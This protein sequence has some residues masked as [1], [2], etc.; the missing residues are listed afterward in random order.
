MNGGWWARVGLIV[1]LLLLAIYTLLPTLL[2]GSAEEELERQAQQV[3]GSAEV[4]APEV[5][6]G[7][8]SFLP[9]TELVL[10]LDLRGGIDLTLDVETDDAVLSSVARDV[11]SVLGAA[12]DD[13]LKLASVDRVR[14]QPALDVA[15]DGAS[16]D[17][18][19]SLFARRFPDYEYT[20]TQEVAGRQAHRFELTEQAQ[21]DIAQRSVEQAVE[22]LRT[23]VDATGVKEPVIVL[24]GGNRINVQLPGVED[25]EQAVAAIGTTAV[26]EF[27]LVDE[28][29]PS[30]EL[31]RNIK[32]ARETAPRN[33]YEDDEALSDWMVDNGLLPADR[34]LLWQYKEEEGA[35]VRSYPYVLKD[36]VVLTGDD[37]NDAQ[38]SM[39]Q[40]NR[41]YVALEF[42]PTGARVFA[43]V[44]GENVG[45]RFAIVLDRRV[46]SA[47]NIR[48]K[49][50][51]GRASIEMGTGDVEAM[52]QDA[53]VLSLVLRT[54]ALPAPL[55]VGEV[56]TVGASL[57]ADSIRQGSEAA[58]VGLV[59]V[60]LLMGVYYRRLGLVA[61]VALVLNVVFIL[62]LMAGFG[63]T[64]TLPGIAGIALTVGMAVDANIIIFERIREELRLGKNARASADAGF[65]NAMSAV[66]DANITTAI[67]GVVL[68]SYGTGPIK[69][70]A[71]TLLIGIAT[72]LFTAVFVSR[73]LVDF[74]V[75]RSDVRLGL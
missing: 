54:G 48:E 25:I 22:T 23:R 37:I 29:Y 39:D 1:A 46:R 26:L 4:E 59:L 35:Q 33:V 40:Y 16:L 45:K 24:K 12:E 72:T 56:R 60:G 64:L 74:L 14:G 52:L 63:S 57:G 68:Y 70:F 3:D 21:A 20:T 10:G 6:T 47:P 53:S 27:L 73:T 11:Q 19:R 32:Q 67:A 50:S 2:A 13:G 43:E 42:K 44:T 62:A 65:D 8:R 31:E 71:V 7:W 38:V 58:I 18:L 41:P 34:L 28:E 5:V 66:L 55:V 61:N 30:D 49:I 36:A 9:D 17:E 51:G 69:G 15:L 75:R